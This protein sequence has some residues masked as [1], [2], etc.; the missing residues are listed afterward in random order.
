[1]SEPT[2]QLTAVKLEVPEDV[3]VILAQSHFVKTV[4]DVHEALVGVSPGLRFGIGFCE[5]S[6]AL[7]VRR[8]G[9]DDELVAAAARGALAIGAGHSVLV[10][11]RGG[12]PVSVLNQLKL[13]PEICHVYCATANPLEVIVIESSQGRGIVGV[14]D[15]ESPRGIEGPADV[16]DRH[17]LLRDIGYKL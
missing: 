9:N 2:L 14:I 1:M 16:A 12:F 4:E 7:L 17:R 13:V 5:A 10:L 15:G 3:N 6:G 11:L 8:S